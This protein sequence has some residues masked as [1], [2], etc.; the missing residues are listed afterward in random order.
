MMHLHL[1]SKEQ[2]VAMGARS[3]F[4]GKP[5]RRGN[6]APR[7]V[8]EGRCL[9]CECTSSKRQYFHQNKERLS[10][11]NAEW[12]KNN[13]EKVLATAKQYRDENKE[14]I[15]VKKALY[16]SANE[17]KISSRKREKYASDPSKAKEQAKRYRQL[18][19]DK[20]ELF[21]RAYRERKSIEIAAKTRSWR[22]NNKDKVRA[23]A[24]QNADKLAAKHARRRARKLNAMPKW[25]C[26]LDE[27]VWQEAAD[28]VRSRRDATGIEWAADHMIPLA[29]KRA[30]GLH[31]W[32]NCQVIPSYQNG[33]KG[34]RMSL[35]EPDEW[36]RHL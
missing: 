26:E 33:W 30:C 5:C 2:A 32:N 19:P 9:C 7:S 36:L 34:N 11:A 3:Y 35:T 21:S 1:I 25:F 4:T 17:E 22:A 8:S 31:V 23:H 24:E 18:N 28:L 10:A 6:S 14:K 13:H 29:A 12:R 15:K 20:V 16:Y 27:F